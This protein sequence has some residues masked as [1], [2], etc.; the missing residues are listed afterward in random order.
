MLPKTLI[1]LFLLMNMANS[2]WE[3]IK[4]I[5]LWYTSV[6][7]LSCFSSKF[8]LRHMFW[9]NG[10]NSCKHPLCSEHDVFS[11]ADA[12]GTLQEGGLPVGLLPSGLVVWAWW[13]CLSWGFQNTGSLRKPAA[14]VWPGDNLPTA[15]LTWTHVLGLLSAPPHSAS[16][17]TRPQHVRLLPA[18]WRVAPCCQWL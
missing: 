7:S 5:L 2:R 17:R 4:R 12:R 1:T 9:N 18:L 6:I 15:P 10:Q 16:T 8:T 11:V 14:L 3:V 13:Y